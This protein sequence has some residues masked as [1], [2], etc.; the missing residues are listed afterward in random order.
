MSIWGRRPFDD[1]G[2][3]FLLIVGSLHEHTVILSEGRI[4]NSPAAMQKATILFVGMALLIAGAAIWS[5]SQR[6]P[7]IV[8]VALIEIGLALT[9]AA[10]LRPLVY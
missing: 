8:D 9:V 2:R 3:I 6:N 1:G 4:F 10:A 5:G 7:S